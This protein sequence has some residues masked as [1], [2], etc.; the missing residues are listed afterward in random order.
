MEALPELR[1]DAL[2]A[3]IARFALNAEH[4]QHDQITRLRACLETSSGPVRWSLLSA[5]LGSSPQ[6]NQWCTWAE[7]R[8]PGQLLDTSVV[9]PSGFATRAT[10]Q[11]LPI[12][13]RRVRA[14]LL[15]SAHSGVPLYAEELHRSSAAATILAALL[16]G[17]ATAFD[18][19]PPADK[20]AELGRTVASVAHELNGPLQAII[21]EAETLSATPHGHQLDPGLQRILRSGLRCRGIVQDLL[22]CG[23]PRP[24]TL[25]AVSISGAIM[26]A[27]DL[28]RWSNVGD[29]EV[30]WNSDH[31][32]PPVLADEARLVQVFSNLL[33]NARESSMASATREPV[34]IQVSRKNDVAEIRITDRGRGVAPAMRARLFEAFATDREGGHGLGLWLSRRMV[35]ECGGSL[36]LDANWSPGAAFVVELPFARAAQEQ[37]E[38][39]RA[40]S[41]LVVDDDREL[42]DTYEALLRLDGHQVT[43]ADR[44]AQALDFLARG[45]FDVILCDLRLPDMTGAAFL[46]EVQAHWPQLAGRV[47]FATGDIGRPESVAFLTSVPNVSLV[48]PFRAEDLAQAIERVRSTT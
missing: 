43:T 22:A 39:P 45:P 42:L 11:A 4:A 9:A 20:L 27:M 31:S 6:E 37:K 3:A 5:G 30:E 2:F 29:V 17:P 41:I 24:A 16:E 21:S 19:L 18:A 23:S 36:T 26:E 33:S 14:W 25:R 28:D 34:R 40:A 35:E 7:S 38:T 44:A 15:A 32:L 8:P 13:G 48:K 10:L 12:P 1:T 46:K 47:I